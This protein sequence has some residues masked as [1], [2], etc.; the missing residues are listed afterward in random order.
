MKRNLVLLVIIW[1]TCQV[2]A[3]TADSIPHHNLG[4][5]AAQTS[6]LMEMTDGSLLGG[7]GIYQEV[8]LGE[9]LHKISRQ[10]LPMVVFDTLFLHY[11]LLPWFLAAKDPRGD[12]NIIAALYNDTS[13]MDCFLE[14]QRFDD[15]LNF[16][17]AKIIVPIA[18]SIRTGNYPGPQLDTNGDIVL[19]YYDYDSSPLEIT[20]ARIGID[21]TVK[22]QKSND[23]LKIDAG[24]LA[25][26]IVFSESPPTYFCWGYYYDSPHYQANVNCYLLDSL[27]DV[28]NFYT[29]PQRSGSPD[30]VDYT[31]DAF[32]TSFLGL[33]DGRFLVARAYNRD[34]YLLPL[35]EDDGVAVMKYDRDFNLLACRKFLSEPYYTNSSFGAKAIGLEKSRDGFVY[36]AYFTHKSS[37][38]S[39]VCVVKMDNDL[40]I[41]WQRHCFDREEGRDY[42]KMIVLDDNSVAVMGINTFYDYGA[43]CLDHSEAFYV[44]VHDDYDALDKQDIIIRPYTFYPNPAQSELHLHYS[45]DVQPARIE[46]YDL[47]GRLLQ[48]QTQGLDNI[49]LEGLAAGQYLMKV[50]LKDGKTFTDKVLKK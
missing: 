16:D 18:H 45:P 17:T 24:R 25:G 19:A 29:L 14:I 32:N 44:I 3:Q 27:F 5:Y 41:V 12:G 39:Q 11:E 38:E 10:E 9:V 30:H 33:E 50:T 31:N 26:P 22:L 47:Q 4:P 34:P 36:F 13:S 43:G 42:G 7:I 8:T 35:I 6:A 1:V 28:T 2:Y 48:T 46:L 21:G 15:S 37:K 49:G 23:S 40:N 20:F